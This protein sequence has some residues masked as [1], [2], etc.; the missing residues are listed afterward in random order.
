MHAGTSPASARA[1][2]FDNPSGHVRNGRLHQ[3]LGGNLERLLAWSLGL[4]LEVFRML[5]K[6]Y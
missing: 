3:E 4:G 5:I 1:V 6:Q 2:G